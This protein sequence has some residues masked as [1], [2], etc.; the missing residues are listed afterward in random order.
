MSPR[1]IGGV[2][3]LIAAIPHVNWIGGVTSVLVSHIWFGGWSFLKLPKPVYLIFL[4]GIVAI[5]IGVAKTIAKDRF[6]SSA[7]FVAFAIYGF[8]WLGLLYDVLITYISSGSSSSTGWYLY[9]VV[10]P[11]VLLIAW[12]VNSLVPAHLRWAVLP[13]IA[14]LFAA[15]DLYGVHFL[16]APY[17]T[18]MIAHVAGSE[19]V[20]PARLSQLLNA[21]PGFILGRLTI[22]RPEFMGRGVIGGLLLLYY[23]ATLAA[24]AIAY[25]AMRALRERASAPTGLRA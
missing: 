9:A 18:G 16:L 8:F 12:A 15:I 17:Y 10:L 11:E 20:H 4:L 22:N 13:A 25:K 23:A 6:R 19:V 21:G 5:V 2:A 14:T 24:V 7:L 1:R 3:H